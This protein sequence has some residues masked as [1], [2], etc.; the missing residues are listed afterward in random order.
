MKFIF[1]TGGVVS[2]LGKG[3]V[4]AS[5]GN[6]LKYRGQK[7]FIMKFDQ[8]LNVDAGTINPTEHGECF[9]TDDGAETDLDLGH[10]ERFIDQNL[11]RESSVMSGQ[12]YQAILENERRGDYLGKTIQMIPHVTDEVKKR[13]I[14]AAKNSRA[15]VTIVEIGGTIGDYEGSHFLEGI[16]QMRRDFGLE[17]TL[18]LHVGF[19]PYMETTHE[20][21]TKPLQNSIRD[22]AS[23]G[24]QPD[25]VFC[26]ADH[27]IKK[28]ELDKI[29][30]FCG[31]DENAVIPVETLDCVYKVPL[32]LEKYHL[33]DVIGKKLNLKLKKSDNSWQKL[34]DK[35]E[36]PKEQIKIAIVG[37]YMD[38]RDTYLSV[39]EALK[40]ACWDNNC[41]L[42]LGWIDSE[43]IEKLGAEKLLKN[44]AGIVVPGGFG[45]RGI[46]GKIAAAR[47]A[48]ENN[49]PCL[50]LCL[51]MQIATIEFARFTLK[52]KDC[53]SEEFSPKTKNPVIH[54]MDS[55][56]HIKEKGGTM[57][58]GAYKCK[59]TAGTI[60]ARAYDQSIISERHR[61][62][63]E[64]NNDY[65]AKLEKSG[66]VVAGINPEQNLVEIIELKDH[67]F[68]VASQFHPE[69]KSRPNRPHPLF[70]EFIKAAKKQR[71]I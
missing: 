18:Y 50:G 59:L 34:V 10:Y 31:I 56:S 36:S 60:A 28:K 51:G 48:R 66:L 70:R 32:L 47:Y 33:G 8:Y 57:R 2:G 4:A 35:I 67:P 17:N 58:L 3:I 68:F 63:F 16:R 52:T 40:A 15:N 49:I 19:F 42:E 69:F 38:M 39:T 64:F 20:L 25:I 45:N 44:F 9:V 55:Q 5:I 30:V 37:K 65:R 13:M 54:L 53:N 29:S 24:I 71:L 27:K 61:H 41:Q 12:I 26:R 14:S 22:L 43:K 46:E 23:F 21:K 7:V 62:R 1:V 11:S 6:I